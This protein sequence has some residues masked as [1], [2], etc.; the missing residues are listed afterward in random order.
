MLIDAHAHIDQYRDDLPQAIAQIKNERILT[1]SVSMDVTSYERALDIS[2]SSSYILPVFGIHPWEAHHYSDRLAELDSY[3][4]RS[5]IIGEMGLDF[6]FIKD[7]A[8]YP[9]QTRV[10]EY[11]LSLAHR[12]NKPV[13]V[14]TK[15]AERAV[16]SA[17][18]RF[19]ISCPIIHWYSGPISLIDS[20]LAANGYFTIG[21]EVL[22]SPKI[23]K[24][25]KIIPADRLL[26]ETDNPGAFQWLTKTQGM[27]VLLKRVVSKLAE[28]RKEDP[29]VVERQVFAN[30]RKIVKNIDQYNKILQRF[31]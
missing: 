27:P 4:Q 3:V 20:F 2:K 25:A 1:V 15:G 10:F 13:N 24:I 16:L 26:T 29:R 28:V 22:S 31:L 14:H 19:H 9:K 5:P 11:L 23:Q 21:M 7:K 6:H 8:L 12:Q 18:E 30:F 17:L